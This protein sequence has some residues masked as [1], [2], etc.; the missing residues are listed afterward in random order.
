M[1]KK[2]TIK[3]YNSRIRHIEILSTELPVKNF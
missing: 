1:R 3:R 2:I